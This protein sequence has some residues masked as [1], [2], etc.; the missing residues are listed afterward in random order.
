MRTPQNVLC[1]WLF[2]I[3]AQLLLH[4]RQVQRTRWGYLPP[5]SRGFSPSQLLSQP[6]SDA[7]SKVG[8]EVVYVTDLPRTLIRKMPG[9]ARCACM[10]L[11]CLPSRKIVPGTLSSKSRSRS[12]SLPAKETDHSRLAV[13]FIRHRSL[14][15]NE[16]QIAMAAC[17]L[18]SRIM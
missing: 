7:R 10:R 3:P 11:N 16:N 9:Q 12:A 15:I 18:G 14:A 2:L 5:T 6:K 13:N 4:K 8:I 17:I 1:G